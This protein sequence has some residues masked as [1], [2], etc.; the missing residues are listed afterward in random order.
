[1]ILGRVLGQIWA[2]RKHPKL[3]GRKLLLI[4]PYG[5]YL[6]AH[7]IGHL[8]AV[9]D[10]DAGPGD[11]VLVCLGWPARETLG[12]QNTP[13]EA[14]VMAIVDRCSFAKSACSQLSRRPLGFATR[15]PNV[16]PKNVEWV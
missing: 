11:D 16:A 5:S 9:D 3:N 14:A 6:P 15:R 10:L 4:E 8:I 7:E 2:S 13:V 1:M 12:D